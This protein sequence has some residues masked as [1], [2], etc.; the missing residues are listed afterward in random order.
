MN[1]KLI[2]NNG[3][4][5]KVKDIENLA[6]HIFEFHATGTS[7]HQKSGHDFAVDHAFR[8]KKY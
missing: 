6:K 8:E 2:D 4:S 1:Y 7:L 3:E 5:Y